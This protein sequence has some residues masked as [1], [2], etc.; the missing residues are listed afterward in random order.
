MG[1]FSPM[2]LSKFWK[3]FTP[4]L[5]FCLRKK[6]IVRI[7]HDLVFSRKVICKHKYYRNICL[8]N[9]RVKLQSKCIIMWAEKLEMLKSIRSWK[10]FRSRN[11]FGPQHFETK[12]LLKIMASKI[13]K[14][15]KHFGSKTHELTLLILTLLLSFQTL[16]LYS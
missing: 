16:I 8:T 12:K 5:N 11:I 15:V 4:E 7:S 6:R 10:H 2:I 13:F 9:A 3:M 14:F 1:N